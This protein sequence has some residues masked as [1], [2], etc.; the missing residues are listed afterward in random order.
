[1]VKDELIKEGYKE[2]NVS[3]APK[4]QQEGKGDVRKG[5]LKSIKKIIAVSSCKGGVGKSTVAINLACTLKELGLKVGIF[6]S[7]IFG[8]SLPTL[9]NKEGETLQARE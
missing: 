7:D 2:V 5:N 1:M 8:P 4:D 6:D 3:L 9:I